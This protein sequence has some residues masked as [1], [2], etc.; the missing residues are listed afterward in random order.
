VSGLLKLTRDA[1]LQH[2]PGGSISGGQSWLLAA[3][4][5]KSFHSLFWVRC[6]TFLPFFGP[7]AIWPPVAFMRPCLHG[8]LARFFF[9]VRL[10]AYSPRWRSLHLVPSLPSLASASSGL[11]SCVIH[12]R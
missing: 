6:A 2:Q 8:I 3:V 11:V 9:T 4:P 7:S 10:E 12:A 1:E 5:S